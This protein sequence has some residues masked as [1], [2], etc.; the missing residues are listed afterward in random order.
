MSTAGHSARGM[1]SRWA[2]RP[3]RWHLP[4][5]VGILVIMW[6][7]KHHTCTVMAHV[8][9]PGQELTRS[10]SRG[11]SG[12]QAVKTGHFGDTSQSKGHRAF[13]LEG[14]SLI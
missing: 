10:K 6:G 2:F 14:C 4:C 8:E 9:L 5:N 12:N 11:T 13:K 7:L 3:F 1:L